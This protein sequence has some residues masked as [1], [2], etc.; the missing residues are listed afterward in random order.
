MLKFL[1]S[2]LASFVTLSERTD[3]PDSFN[4]ELNYQGNRMMFI[5][6][7]IFS[8]VWLPYIAFDRAFMPQH[9]TIILIRYGMSLIGILSLILHLTVMKKKSI[10]LATM[11]IAYMEIGVGVITGISGGSPNYMGGY[12]FCLCLLLMIPI[13]LWLSIGILYSSVATLF[14][15]LK[16]TNIDFSSLPLTYRYTLQDLSILVLVLTLF[17]FIL[18]QTRFQNWS[19]SKTIEKQRA[20]MKESKE[21]HEKLLLNILPQ[22][23]AQELQEKGKSD[24]IYYESATIMFTDFLGFT[25]IAESM[26][27][28]QLVEEL[29][30]CFSFFD[31]LMDK[32]NLEKLKTIGD[33]YM[34]IAGVPV[35]NS[36]HAVDSVL[37]ALEIQSFMREMQQRRVEQGLPYWE[38]RIGINSGHV[39]AGVIGQKK[40]A[41]D[42]WSDTVNTASRC[43]SEGVAGRVNISES[44]YEMIK[45]YFTC[46][47]RGKISAKNKGEIGMYLVDRAEG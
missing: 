29:D 11:L 16:S 40:F 7:L 18:N 10:A 19:K 44:T 20:A 14:L 1:K 2:Q 13:P 9:L 17:L 39:V 22:K 12:F 8:I 37:A 21:K 47:Y 35:E 6:C 45:D 28:Q 23:I 31:T 5:G 24:P 27:P 4:G 43:E 46:E 34:C 33:S 32:Y 3:Y 41:Y 42:V 38:L 25:T 26:A 36:S 30:V 15:V